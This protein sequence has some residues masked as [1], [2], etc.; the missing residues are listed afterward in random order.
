MSI[1]DC[2]FDTF[3]NKPGFSPEQ[4]WL[5]ESFDRVIFYQVNRDEYEDINKSFL[6]GQYKIPVE[7]GV[8]DL[9]EYNALVDSTR[10]E[11]AGIRKRQEECAAEELEKLVKISYLTVSFTNQVARE[12]E[13]YAQWTREKDAQRKRME[14]EKSSRNAE[15]DLSGM[16]FVDAEK[17]ASCRLRY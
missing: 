10:E 4:P 15:A 7:D 16:S 1:H 5:F 17:R 12:N 11:V 8:F 6:S 3:G 14:L 13:L 2:A 9:G